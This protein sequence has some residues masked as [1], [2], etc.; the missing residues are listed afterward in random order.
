MNHKRERYV[1][2]KLLFLAILIVAG[3]KGTQADPLFFSNVSALQNNGAT[4][5]DLFSSPG[6]TLIGP[7]LTF[8]VDITGNLNSGTTDTLVV[9][10]SEAGGSPIIQSFQIPLFGTLQPPF[11]LVFSVTSLVASFAG[12]SATLTLDLINSN[13]DFIIPAGPNAGQR[14]DSNSYS[15]NVS[16]PI[17][18]PTAL[19]LL[20]AGLTGL[21]ARSRRR[22]DSKNTPNAEKLR[23]I[24]PQLP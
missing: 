8:L 10:F 3:A 9:S 21:L 7:Q 24:Q 1:R 19:T 11:T 4:R 23:P 5:V 6:T 12:T 14:V 2:T 15:F 13:P 20:G 18:E 17:P 22:R 16:K